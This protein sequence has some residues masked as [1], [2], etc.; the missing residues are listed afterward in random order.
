MT[1]LILGA[2][3]LLAA[4]GQISVAT[5]QT[6]PPPPPTSAPPPPTP[7][8]LQS[9]PWWFVK[10]QYRPGA[11]WFYRAAGT[12]AARQCRVAYWYLAQFSSTDQWGNTST[13]MS[14]A[15]QYVCD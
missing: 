8:N 2:L 7:P 10:H 12:P 6:S 14:Y 1:K 3:V 5:A 11:P 9:L 15:P 4:V 13:W